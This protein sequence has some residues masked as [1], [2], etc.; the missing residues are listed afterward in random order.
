MSVTSLP[1]YNKEPGEEELV[2]FRSV[3]MDFLYP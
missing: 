3:Y 1:E 2:I